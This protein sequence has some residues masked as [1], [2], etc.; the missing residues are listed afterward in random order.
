MAGWVLLAAT[1]PGTIVKLSFGFWSD[2]VSYTRRIIVSS[3]TP[4]IAFFLASE[5]ESSVVR[6]AGVG[7]V[8]V[9]GAIGE[10]TFLALTAKYSRRAIGSWSSG[11]GGAG[12]VGAGF[13]VLLSD[14]FGLTSQM[15]L[16][17]AGPTPLV[18]LFIYLWVL[19]KKSESGQVSRRD[20]TGFTPERKLLFSGLFW[21]FILPLMAVYYAEYTIN[22]GVLPTLDTFS[23][24]EVPASPV[25]YARYQLLYQVGVFISRSSISLLTIP[26]R[27]LWTLPSLQFLNLAVFLSQATFQWIQTVDII[28]L[29]ILWEGLIGGAA[30]VNSFHEI[31]R[32][33]H[34]KD[35]EW[36]LSVATVGDSI[37]VLLASVTDT[38]LECQIR[39]WQGQPC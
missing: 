27:L 38:V 18:I 26:S 3:I 20:G 7:L 24:S 17:V 11:T 19:K 39:F 8:S 23:K 36:A 15:T 9:A 37:G 21:K 14:Q 32:T 28:Y 30:Y 34:P 31:S 29:L 12:I 16:R 5:F 13:F 25:L 35:R 22:Q 2:R 6:L 1:V 4:C 33:T 10:G